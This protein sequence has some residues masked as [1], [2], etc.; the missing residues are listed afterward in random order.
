M[1]LT[2]S[3][4]IH[5]CLVTKLFIICVFFFKLI[6]ILLY[7][8]LVVLFHFR[9]VLKK[10]LS[11]SSSVSSCPSFSLSFFH[12]DVCRYGAM[13]VYIHGDSCDYCGQNSLH[14]LHA[15]QRRSHLAVNLVLDPAI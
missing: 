11:L 15:H 10:S 8:Y 1:E 12:I 2:G 13:C 4:P 9:K 14:P 7:N 5:A 3:P 6:Q